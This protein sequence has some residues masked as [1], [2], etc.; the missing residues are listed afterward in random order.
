MSGHFA[1]VCAFAHFFIEPM[2]LGSTLA[3]HPLQCFLRELTL[4]SSPVAILFF[5]ALWLFK[6][7]ALGLQLVLQLI[8]LFVWDGF[9]LLPE[10][11]SSHFAPV[12]AFALCFI[13]A[14]AVASSLV[15]CFLWNWLAL[16]PEKM[17]S[18]FAAV[19]AFALCFVE[20]LTLFF[21]EAL[22][23]ASSLVHCLIWNWLALLPKESSSH[24]A[25]VRTFAL[26]V[27]EA[28]ALASSLVHAFLW[29]TLFPEKVPSNFTTVCDFAL[30]F[31]E[32]MALETH[33]LCIV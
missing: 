6:L 9:A 8:K 21:V 23:L 10:E 5:V 7:P 1:T 14:T 30:F 15:H 19:F 26:F 17:P 4:R 29:L 20:A 22:T 27:I 11:S 3:H 12:C 25:T 16:F 31:T 2:A 18:H 24:F 28:L 33:Q 13:K 32:A